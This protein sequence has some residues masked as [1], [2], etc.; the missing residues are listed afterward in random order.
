MK[1]LTTSILIFFMAFLIT[2]SLSA[3]PMRGKKKMV[4]N[5]LSEEKM[6]NAEKV[7]GAS[8]FSRKVKKSKLPQT[9]NLDKKRKKQRDP[10]RPDALKGK[11][12]RNAKMS[13][14]KSGK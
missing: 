3:Q 2:T 10:N 4:P 1:K 11:Q 5:G 12:K 9:T 14:E 7:S 6:E 8:P 13:K